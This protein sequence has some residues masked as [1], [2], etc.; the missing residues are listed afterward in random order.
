MNPRNPLD[1]D[2]IRHDFPALF[3]SR[4]DR[5]PIFLDNACSTIPCQAVIDSL[6]D[7]CL[8]Y[9]ACGER[10][11]HYWGRKVDEE[12]ARA[13]RAIAEFIHAKDPTQIIFV[14]NSTEGLN[15]VG[16]GLHWEKGDVVVTGDRE[17]NS[18]RC[19]WE[20]L[21]RETGI[22]RKV[23][24]RDGTHD[25][26]SEFDVNYFLGEL[27]ETPRVKLVSL[28][29]TSNLDGYTI[30]SEAI[31]RVTAYAHSEVLR[32][33]L[34]DFYVMLDAAQT[35]PHQAVDVQD[36]DV[37]FLAFSVHKMC[38][39][40]GL[41]VCYMKDPDLL[42]R[43][44]ITGGG[45][46]ANTFDD[47]RAPIYLRSPQKYE[48][49]LQHWSGILGAG[50]AADYLK[51]K[52]VAL[53]DRELELNR[54]LTEGF[55]PYHEKEVITILGP[56]DP[57]KRGSICTIEVHPR[58]EQEDMGRFL[59]EEVLSR[60]D[61]RNLMFRTGDFCV[62]PYCRHVRGERIARIRFSL[63]LYNTPDECRTALDVFRPILAR[64]LP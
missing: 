38:G 5:P 43:S 37:D 47:G 42:E 26:G 64:R 52:M 58:D 10:S 32:R 36:L 28:A 20:D 16:R 57:A 21:G 25:P 34:K 48:A 22:R 6:N 18:N 19:C 46:V 44:L 35:V 9:P 39:P 33:D 61:E 13:R 41:G 11:L 17:H 29:L 53:S 49:G 31:R 56:L 60:T 55:M 54:I 45:T 15:L 51:D 8:N 23:I 2:A 1:W 14:K 63:Y 7:Y 4:N 40:T 62:S 30:P 50:V 27:A 12:V 59:R 3:R 24:R